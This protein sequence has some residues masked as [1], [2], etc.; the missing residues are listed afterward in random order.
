MD[1]DWH[2][3]MIYKKKYILG[4]LLGTEL[5]KPLELPVIRIKQVSFVKEVISGWPT[6][7]K[8]WGVDAGRGN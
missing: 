4:A 2:D 3:I 1:I 6:G 5:L 7:N 8:G